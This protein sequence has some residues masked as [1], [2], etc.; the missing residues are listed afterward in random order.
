MR[1]MRKLALSLLLLVS[2]CTP[3]QLAAVAAGA[4]TAENVARAGCAILNA[5]GTSQ[6]VLA[7]LAALQ[8][9]IVEADAAAAARNGADKAVIAALLASTA[10]M[11]DALRVNAEQI[12][13][14]AGE[15]RPVALA[16]CPA[17]LLEP[18]DAGAPD[19]AP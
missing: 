16:P 4:Q 18:A 10:R 14:L 12:G 15:A 11:A 19:A 8:K 13:A 3:A 1:T 17:P 9:A 7:G 6:E 5:G 2:S